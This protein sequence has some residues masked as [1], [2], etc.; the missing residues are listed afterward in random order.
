MKLSSYKVLNTYVFFAHLFAIFEIFSSLL[1]FVL[2]VFSEVDIHFVL[3][4]FCCCFIVRNQGVSV[5]YM[6][7]PQ[8]G[9]HG[10]NFTQVL[11]SHGF[12]DFFLWNQ[13]SL[14]YGIFGHMRESITEI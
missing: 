14:S 8:W 13:N 10:D 7:T 4:E 2:K 1:D 12:G 9:P 5:D 11:G 3:F 6:G